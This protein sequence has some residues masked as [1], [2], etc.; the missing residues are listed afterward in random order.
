MTR[1]LFRCAPLALGCALLSCDDSSSGSTIDQGTGPSSWIPDSLSPTP[2]VLDEVVPGNVDLLDERGEDPGWV[3]IANISSRPVATGAWRLRGEASDGAPWTLPDTILPPGGRMLVFM[4]GLDL[5][6]WIPS[7][8]TVRGFNSA[9]SCWADEQNDPPGGSA[10]G[11]WEFRRYAGKARVGADSV[12][13]F[14]ASLLLADNAG[15]EIDW[16]S[17]SLTMPMAGNKILDVSGRDRMRV[18]A[19]IPA[20]QPLALRFCED[21]Q[22]CWK[23]TAIQLVG[24]GVEQDDYEFSLL[25]VGT[26]FRILK[27]IAFEPPSNQFGTYRFTVSAV[28]FFRSERRPH[29]SFELHRKGG[30]IGVEDSSGALR[31][32]V[33]YPEMPATSSWARVPGTLRYVVRDAPTPGASNPS[34]EPPSILPAPAFATATGFHAGPVVVRLGEVAGTVVRCSENGAALTVAS[35]DASAGIRLDSTRAL[36]CA[37]FAPDGRRGPAT[38]GIFLIGEASTL[39]VVSLVADSSALFDSV[40]GIYAMGPGASSEYPYFGANFW[41]DQEIPAHVEFYEP[42]GARGFSADAGIGIFGNYSRAADKKPL[43]VQFREKY[44]TRR[45][46][47]P[48][49]PQHPEFRRF[50]GFALR[51]NGGN[52]GSE[53]VRDAL[54]ATLVEGRDLENQISR[55]VVVYLN[56]RYWGIY[57]M[58]ERLDAD[59]FDTRFGIDASQLDLLKNGGEVQAGTAGGWSSLIDWALGADFA[60][61]ANWERSRTLLD[62]DNFATYVSAEIFYAN[63]DWPAN[64]YRSWRRNSPATPWRMVLFDVDAGIAGFSKTTDMFSFLG[65]SSVVEEYPN[66]PRSTVL[67]RR[68]SGNATWRNRFVNRMCVLLATNFSTARATA[69]YDSML[70]AIAPE[71]PR[72]Q[73]RWGL[74]STSTKS[75]ETRIRQFLRNRPQLVRR[76]M[77][78]WYGLGDSMHVSLSAPGG[79]I[80]VDGLSVGSAYVGTHFSGV[81]A[82]LVAVPPPGGGFAGWSDGVASAERVVVLPDSD[83]SLTAVFR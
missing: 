44:G 57:D 14:S 69:V 46:D 50:K 11:Y 36:T 76:H 56:G 15:T 45:I 75:Q 74:P 67:F 4:S 78:A 30:T 83:L 62:V 37:A 65:D 52:S 26:D 68:L 71:V 41:R 19:T 7:G 49:F 29:A 9:V 3:E 47:W 66:G 51:N 55:Q 25:G 53:Y 38:T 39:A 13:A 58:R 31:Q 10:C 48:L 34:D 80:Q 73:A 79:S 70:A 2:L 24:T 22:E 28:D 61:S 54:G 60:D 35:S 64:N 72:D 5:R 40:A 16:A 81:P 18:R 12:P 59:Y 1:F 63:D 23:G 27:S 32:T 77:D 21:G 42:G 17:A 8:D 33:E 6:R 20:G 43:S 82:T